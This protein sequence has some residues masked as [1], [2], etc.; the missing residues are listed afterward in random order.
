MR[1][2]LIVLLLRV[3][4]R[5]MPEADGAAISCGPIVVPFGFN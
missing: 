5:R 4:L 1:L 2:G 3:R